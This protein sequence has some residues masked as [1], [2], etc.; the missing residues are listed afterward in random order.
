MPLAQLAQAAKF[1]KVGKAMLPANFLEDLSSGIGKGANYL[2]DTSQTAA[3]SARKAID[4]M[5]APMMLGA[6]KV[7]QDD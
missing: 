3:K 6:D 7:P 5:V 2:K 1:S 4:E